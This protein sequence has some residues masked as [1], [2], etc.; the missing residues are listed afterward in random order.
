MRIYGLKG[1]QEHIRGQT[2]LAH[3][4]EKLVEKDARFELVAPVVMG[5]VCFRMKVCILFNLY[6]NFSFMHISNEIC[7]Y[8]KLL[9]RIKQMRKTGSS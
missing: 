4:F 9:L 7:F 6:A 8:A 2:K 3:E 1:L 5:L